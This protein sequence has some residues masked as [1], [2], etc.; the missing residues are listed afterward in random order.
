[1]IEL[2]IP[3]Y[4]KLTLENLAIDFNGTLAFEGRLSNTAREIINE[5][6]GQLK[7]YI[8]TADSFGT[9]TQECN[10]INAEVVIIDRENGGPDKLPCDV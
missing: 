9:V 10:G 5:L 2:S 8:L 3:G 1:M 6:A 7:V 4:R